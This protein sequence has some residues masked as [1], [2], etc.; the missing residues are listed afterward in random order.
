MSL[1]LEF[2]CILSSLPH[3]Q[4]EEGTVP[5]RRQILFSLGADGRFHLWK[6]VSA[7]REVIT[8]FK[9]GTCQES[10][11]VPVTTAL[12]RRNQEDQE[13]KVSLNALVILNAAWAT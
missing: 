5:R 4:P 13:F 6:G 11:G 7:E 2:P 8:W 1:R 9:I 12:R 10:W 3:C